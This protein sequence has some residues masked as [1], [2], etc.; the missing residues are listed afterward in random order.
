MGESLYAFIIR[1]ATGGAVLAWRLERRRLARSGKSAWTLQNVVLTSWLLSAMLFI[2]LVGLFG[3]GVLPWLICQAVVAV[4]LL[5]AINY[6]E[7]YG[8]RRQRRPDG[9]YESV[10]PS[11]SWNSNT[12]VANV[13]LF[14]LQR[15]SDHHAHPLR[16]YQA[17]RHDDEAPQLP[18]GYATMLLLAAFP[19]LWRRVMDPRVL[20]HY[21]GDIRLAALNPRREKR[22]LHRYAVAA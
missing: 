10:R 12:V 18:A 16:R 1:S 11:H 4:C 6:I 7:H 9:G 14:H 19:P 20:A 13:F 3:L 21:G 5:E 2:A 17:L 22:L 15:H 8:L